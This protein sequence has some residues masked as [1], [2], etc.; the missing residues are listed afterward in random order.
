[1]KYHYNTVHVYYYFYYYLT[2]FRVATNPP[3]PISNMLN[4]LY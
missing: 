2:T 4:R 3:T 1:M